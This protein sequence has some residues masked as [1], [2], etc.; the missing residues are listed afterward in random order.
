MTRVA[1]LAALAALLA[2][3]TVRAQT[4]TATT[5]IPAERFSPAVGPAS[6]VGVEGAMVTPPGAVSWAGSVDWVHEPLT[7]RRAFSGDG[8]SRPVRDALVTDVALEFG[9]WK[10]IAAAV[11]VPVVLYQS[12]D[13]GRVSWLCRPQAIAQQPNRQRRDAPQTLARAE[14]RLHV[15]ARQVGPQV[16]QLTTRR[17]GHC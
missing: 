2:P 4:V 1:W 10:R 13:R 9:L 15:R 12:G 11:G 14:C 3:A 16:L 7:L 5:A 8:V 6:L 17:R